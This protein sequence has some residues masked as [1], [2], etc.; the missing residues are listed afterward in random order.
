[1]SRARFWTCRRCQVKLPR[2]KQKCPECGATRPIRKTAAQK[3]LAD[4]YAVWETRFG[5]VCGIC[6]RAASQRRCISTD[7]VRPTGRQH[8][9]CCCAHRPCAAFGPAR[10]RRNDHQAEAGERVNWRLQITAD[11]ETGTAEVFTFDWAVAVL[12]MAMGQGRKFS[13]DIE[14]VAAV[15]ERSRES[16]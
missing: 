6:G 14:P 3:A 5:A 8:E 9:R 10:N 7:I 16:A 12:G 13:V 11:G 15:T 2:T 4:E 1:M